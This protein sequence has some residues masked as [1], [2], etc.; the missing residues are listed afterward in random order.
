VVPEEAQPSD[1]VA[2]RSGEGWLHDL[3]SAIISWCKVVR[4][5]K[6]SALRTGVCLSC[7]EEGP[8]LNTV[9]EPVKPASIPAAEG[10]A[11]DAQLVS[12]NRSA[13]GRGGRIR[14]ANTPIC[15][16]CGSRSMGALNLLLADPHHRHRTRDSVTAWWVSEP[17]PITTFAAIRDARP[18]QVEDIVDQVRMPPARRAAWLVHNRFY[19]VTLSA[20]HSRVVVRDWIEIPLIALL[21]NIDA[22]F[23]EHAMTDQWGDGAQQVPSGKMAASLGRYDG[24]HYVKNSEPRAAERD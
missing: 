19:A 22:W 2:I 10:R 7:G 4:S 15:D 6:S 17:A 18:E 23:V 16:T 24:Q 9:P 14:L 13:Q 3:P 12:I 5:R 1:V 20:N 11:R 21:Q 8:L